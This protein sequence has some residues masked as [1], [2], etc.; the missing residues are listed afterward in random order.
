MRPR[1]PVRKNDLPSIETPAPPLIE[2]FPWG[3][4]SN[5]MLP[6][7]F[8]ERWVRQVQAVEDRGQLLGRIEVVY[9]LHDMQ[10]TVAVPLNTLGDDALNHQL[11]D[12]NEALVMSN[13]IA[14]MNA[15]RVEQELVDDHQTEGRYRH[16]DCNCD[17]RLNHPYCSRATCALRVRIRFTRA[18]VLSEIV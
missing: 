3:D 18:E 10:D 1:S 14:V 13:R 5:E 12:T 11:V 2:T 15:G 16:T 8:T 4:A 9:D 7:A 6:V 17:R